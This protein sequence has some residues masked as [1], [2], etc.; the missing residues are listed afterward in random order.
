VRPDAASGPVLKQRRLALVGTGRTRLVL[1]LGRVEFLASC[2]LGMLMA[3]LKRCG[4][5]GR[6]AA[7]PPSSAGAVLPRCSRLGPARC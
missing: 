5:A 4:E 2:G 3:V 6:C 1:G 7:V